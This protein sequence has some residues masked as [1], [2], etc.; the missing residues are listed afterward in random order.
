MW[1]NAQPSHENLIVS[2]NFELS[3]FTDFYSH[4]IKSGMFIDEKTEMLF[5]EEN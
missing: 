1:A 5:Y 4:K 3:H 2:K